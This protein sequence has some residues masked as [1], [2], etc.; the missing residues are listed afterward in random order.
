M[1]TEYRE[2][3][4][5]IGPLQEWKGNK[6][7]TRA[8]KI[9]SNGSQDTL[10]VHATFT[11][12]V[13][14]EPNISNIAIFNLSTDTIKAIRKGGVSVQL[15]AGYEGQTKSLVYSGSVMRV[16]VIRQGADTVANLM[17]LSGGSNLVRS[18]TSKTYTRGVS[19]SSVV[20]ELA[21]RIPGVEV[22]DANIK[23]QGIIGYSGWSFVGMTKDAIDKLAYQFGFSWRI[24]DGKFIA[25]TDGKS[26]GN[27]TLLNATNGLLMISP[28]LSGPTLI[29]EG[30]SIKAQFVP[31]VNPGRLVRVVSE[32]NPELNGEYVCHTIEFDLCPKEEA[33]S[34]N[35]TSFFTFGAW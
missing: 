30:V 14:S 34:M 16:G 5:Y 35:I 7:T 27:A 28:R 18:K 10:K 2:L 1:N 24:E 6:G 8:I 3:E 15:F 13:T 4:L 9:V 22:D 31:N 20:K 32:T 19:V 11:K 29:Q 23:I 25:C 12:N 26:M 21:S 17:C 33:W